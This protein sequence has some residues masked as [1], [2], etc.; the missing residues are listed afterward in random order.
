MT[1]SKEAHFQDPEALK[2]ERANAELE[3]FIGN[4]ALTSILEGSGFDTT[5]ADTAER[6]AYIKDALAFAD[7]HWNVRK[8]KERGEINWGGTLA[9]ESQFYE[10]FVALGM[11]ESS[12]LA[13]E[14]YDF[15]LVL[16][17]ANR[18]PLQRLQY[19]LE[20][21][22]HY[23]HIALLGAGRPVGKA[24]LAKVDD[25]APGAQTEYDLM[26][27]AA[28]TLLGDSLNADEALPLNQTGPKVLP[29]YWK[30]NYFETTDGQHV[31]SLHSDYEVQNTRSGKNRAK[32]GDTYKFFRE[33]AGDMLDTDT[34]VALA[35]NAMF[36]NAQRL[37][38]VRELT[39]QT[40]VQVDTIGFSADY[41][42]VNRTEGQ[43]LQELKAAISAADRLQTSLSEK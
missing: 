10:Q 25:Y 21:E 13:G 16:G 17:G 4:P 32:T 14:E 31:F 11:V 37:D 33:L 19:G 20:Q 9:E 5:G 39:L 38:A 29:K 36:I 22:V 26:D 1:I 41:A 6:G 12:K 27:G 2:F 30:L 7:E 40:G 23:K 15:L 3:A 42:G 8:H 43:L 24:E 28:R 34:Q 18:S 35:T